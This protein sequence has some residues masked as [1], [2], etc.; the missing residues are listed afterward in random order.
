MNKNLDFLL[1]KRLESQNTVLPKDV[2][3]SFCGK[4]KSNW[5]CWHCLVALFECSSQSKYISLK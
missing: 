2:V 4:K 3:K 5:F 1:T